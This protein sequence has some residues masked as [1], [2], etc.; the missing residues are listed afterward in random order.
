MS[1]PHKSSDDTA[2]DE[3]PEEVLNDP[4]NDELVLGDHTSESQTDNGLRRSQRTRRPPE[5]FGDYV[6][7]Q[8]QTVTLTDWRDRVS[9][10]LA[11]MP[12]FPAQQAE[13]V[14]AMVHVISV[15]H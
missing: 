3:L 1:S 5:R 7:N 8:V 11:L 12:V 9:I 6:T 4:E 15:I 14:S 2:A 10:L 13:F